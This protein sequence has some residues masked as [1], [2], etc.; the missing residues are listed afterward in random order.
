MPEAN[1]VENTDPGAIDLTGPIDV[2]GNPVGESL[3]GPITFGVDDRPARPRS[4]RLRAAGRDDGVPLGH[5]GRPGD[6]RPNCSRP[7]ASPSRLPA[8]ATSR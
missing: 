7:P 4:A 6:C 1:F 3:V 2:L 5:A 8:T